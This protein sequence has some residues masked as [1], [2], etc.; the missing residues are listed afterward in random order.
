LLSLAASFIVLAATAV[1]TPG[2][3][4]SLGAP[5][6]SE[7]TGNLHFIRN[8]YLGHKVHIS[9]VSVSSS[10]LRPPNPLSHKL[11]CPPRNRRGVHTRLQVR[12][13]KFGR[14]DKKHSIVYSVFWAI[15]CMVRPQGSDPHPLPLGTAKE[16][17]NNL[18]KQYPPPPPLELCSQTI[19]ICKENLFFM[20]VCLATPFR[21]CD[22][23][24]QAKCLTN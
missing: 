9:P 5:F 3:S 11:V 7:P 10:E 22:L 21:R 1:F 23:P 8:N 17:R 15:Y 6:P 16:G 2:W 4:W 12:G 13:S 19:S 14:L 20:T 24:L 18:N